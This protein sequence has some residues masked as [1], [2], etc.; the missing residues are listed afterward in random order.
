[1]TPA[2]RQPRT[3]EHCFCSLRLSS[4]DPRN[5]PNAGHALV[6]A[7][8]SVLSL[9]H[10]AS[11]SYDT[12]DQMES[13]DPFPCSFRP[14]H[15][16]PMTLGRRTPVLLR[17]Y[18]S[19]VISSELG[20][21]PCRSGISRPRFLIYCLLSVVLCPCLSTFTHSSFTAFFR[22]TYSLV[23]RCCSSFCFM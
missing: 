7:N 22:P 17:L 9:L 12:S 2:K 6:P 16:E 19:W 1:L 13:P 8:R 14:S 10:G 5:V 18:L 3:V 4:T 20:V 23:L 15:A 21:C 11:S